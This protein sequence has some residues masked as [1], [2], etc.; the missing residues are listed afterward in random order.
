MFKERI[1]EPTHTKLRMRPQTNICLS[2]LQLLWPIPS[3]R[4]FFEHRPSGLHWAQQM[5]C[6]HAVPHANTRL[7]PV[8]HCLNGAGVSEAQLP[9]TM[10]WLVYKIHP[11]L[12]HKMHNFG[13]DWHMP[14]Y[15][16]CMLVLQPGEQRCD[17]WIDKIE[18]MRNMDLPAC[19]PQFGIY[20]LVSVWVPLVDALS[21]TQLTN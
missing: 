8:F 1:T 4:L 5:M 12:Y 6:T 16:S 20:I 3:P 18:N 21:G 15:V 10:Q 11:E 17:T 13:R 19:L 2:H 9:V 14:F 7:P